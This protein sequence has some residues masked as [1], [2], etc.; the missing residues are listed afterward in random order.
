VYAN[1]DVGA[2][3]RGLRGEIAG[4]ATALLSRDG[5][6]LSADLP[7]SGWAETFGLL[8]ATA[9]GAAA[10]ANAELGRR[11]PERIEVRGPD[12]TVFIVGCGPSALLVAVVPSGEDARGALARVEAL[13]GR[14][15]S[16]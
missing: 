12:S 5:A 3:V 11:P 6:V 16:P 8:C 1:A 15:T 2:L 10:A 4:A 7:A 14:L 9:F 13:V